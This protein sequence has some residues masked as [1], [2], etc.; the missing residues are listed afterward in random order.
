LGDGGA[1]AGAVREVVVAVGLMGGECCGVTWVVGAL[2]E[3]ASD[4][5]FSSDLWMKGG[6]R[7]LGH[8]SILSRDSR[9]LWLRRLGQLL[10]YWNNMR[11]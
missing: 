10:R 8:H 6:R 5:Q 4:C 9:S 3:A 11:P 1:C 7:T 2:E